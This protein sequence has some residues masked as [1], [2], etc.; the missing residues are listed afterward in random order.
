MSYNIQCVRLKAVTARRRL[1]RHGNVE[2]SVRIDRSQRLRGQRNLY[3]LL[4]D[5]LPSSDAQMNLEG[6]KRVHCIGLS[7]H[8]MMKS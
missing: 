7:G 1:F 4:G 3:W 8:F 6:M 5:L 2:A